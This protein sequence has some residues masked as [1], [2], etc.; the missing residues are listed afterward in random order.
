MKVRTPVAAD[1]T[2][3]LEP[4][5]HLPDG[6]PAALRAPGAALPAQVPGCVH[7]DLLAAGLIPDPYLDRNETE[8]AW[9]G[10]ADWSYRAE[11][12]AAPTGH[13]RVDLVFE[14]LDTVAEVTLDG[15]RLGTTRNMHRSYRFDATQA[16]ADGSP[17]LLEVAF[18]SAYAEAEG[19]RAA[20]G[21]RPNAYPEPFNF[22]RKMASSFGWDWGPTLVTAGIWRPVRIEQWS[23]ARLARV[24]PHVTVDAHGEDG[25]VGTVRVVLDLER[26]AR[27]ADRAL[28][29]RVEVA[30]EHAEVAVAPGQDTAEA[31]V[32]VARPQLWWP[33]GYGEQARYDCTV[34]LL[35][36]DAH[37]AGSEGESES[38][39]EALDEWREAIGFRSVVLD[40]T[41]DAAGT[42][43]TLVVN[44]EPVFA[45]GVNWI[46]DD[47]LPVRVTPERYRQRLEQ[48]V[49]AGVNLVRVWGGGLY[50]DRAFYQACDELG[51]MVWQDFLFACAAYPEEEP[52]RSE[53]E[54]EAREN[55]ARLMPHP[56]LVLWNGN[57]ENLWGFRDWG[58]AEKLAG[59]SWGEG[60]YLDLLPRVTAETDPTRPYWAG[61]PWSGSWAHEPND[62]DHGTVHSW[63]VWNR[64]DYRDY[65]DTAP[66]FVAE[67]GWQAPA[68]W[69]TVRRSVSDPVLTPDSPAMLH[70]Q[71]A[72]DGQGKLNRGLAPYFDV[73][74]ADAPDGFDRWHY[75]TQ[76]NQARAV[77]TG[78]EHWRS[79]W[80]HCAGTIVW[81][82]NDCWPV[83]SWAAIDG[84]GRLKPLYH[85]LR[86]LYADRLLSFQERDGRPCL[87]VDNQAPDGWSPELLLRRVDADGTVLAE[88]ALRPRVEPRSVLLL[89]LPDA[90]ASL[91]DPRREL[92]T[93]DADGL[94]A[95]RL[96][97]ADREFGFKAAGLEVAVATAAEGTAVTV[98]A[99]T[100]VHDL[101]LQADRLHP[102][103]RTDR[104]RTTLLPGEGATFLVDSWPGTDAADARAEAARAALFCVN[105]TAAQSTSTGTTAG[106]GKTR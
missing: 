31:V 33:R 55:V 17:A 106:S 30:G 2:L 58:W 98:T 93:A 61:T 79:H 99:R 5:R 1:W 73:P 14:G 89:P 18:T 19:V 104:G 8:V 52:L 87:A 101:L 40:T 13:E 70:H 23:T 80:P 28:L 27:G 15:R 24:R 66:R 81:Q 84:D 103:A 42:P 7:T 64:R 36:A 44:G 100:L 75:L 105:P 46:P 102:D 38:G 77:A 65:L 97:C 10:R 21:E 35:D 59:A 82:L 11:V 69:A 50:E 63:E 22:V 51:L 34:T 41:P 94:R 37:A 90:V 39:P 57:N 53:V 71:K 47:A 76:L 95:V 49:G 78:I 25:A 68:A 32:T 9:V 26:T 92:W 88:V 29:V 91:G 83:T 54:A 67:F 62:P 85:E 12:A 3:R 56:S 60:Y 20:L 74:P 45:R 4:A 6:A 16:L 48:A 86:R 43:F 96:G 72:D